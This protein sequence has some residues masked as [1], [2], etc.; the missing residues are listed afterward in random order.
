MEVN[1]HTGFV[2]LTAN[3]PEW[4]G[5]GLTML[6]GYEISHNNPRTFFNVF[7]YET[8]KRLEDPLGTK[9]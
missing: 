3:P 6:N 7:T 9:K 2:V 4:S 8:E 1:R 5:I